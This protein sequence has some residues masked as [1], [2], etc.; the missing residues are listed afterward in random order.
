[1]KVTQC[2]WYLRSNAIGKKDYT[3]CS[4]LGFIKVNNLKIH[5]NLLTSELFLDYSSC[6]FLVFIKTEQSE[7][8]DKLC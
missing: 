5:T 1:M 6:S 8:T 2:S 7:N 3:S 4:F